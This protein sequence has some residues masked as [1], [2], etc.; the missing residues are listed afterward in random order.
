[1]KKTL[2]MLTLLS[3]SLLGFTFDIWESSISLN[4]TIV[5]AK[6]KNIALAKNNIIHSSKSF[7]QKLLYSEQYP[8][9]RE[10]YYKSELLGESSKIDLYFTKNSKKLYK[11]KVRWNLTGKKNKVLKEKLYQLLD[12]KY[13]KS[14]TITPL[15]IGDFIF[16][17]RRQWTPN[18][19]TTIQSKSSTSGIEVIYIDNVEFQKNEYKEKAKEAKKELEFLKKDSQ[20]F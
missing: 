7:N 15:N 11:I 19:E 6:R 20:K 5:I 17:K 14:E 12:E 4:K 16:F 3:S 8:D 13:G 18:K 2:L 9:N 1:M 10:F